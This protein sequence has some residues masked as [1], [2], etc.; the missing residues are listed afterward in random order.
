[1]ELGI[2]D[3][4]SLITPLSQLAF[5][6]FSQPK[7]W[8]CSSLVDETPTNWV[9]SAEIKQIVCSFGNCL[10]SVFSTFLPNYFQKWRVSVLAERQM[11][12]RKWT[13]MHQSC[14]ARVFF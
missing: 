4:F 8:H 11:E 5:W 12:H 3:V 7:W 14:T 9:T 2:S 6:E 1:M 10:F 13:R